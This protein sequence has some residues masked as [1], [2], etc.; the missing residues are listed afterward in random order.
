MIVVNGEVSLDSKRKVAW[1]E[2]EAELGEVAVTLGIMLFFL[3]SSELD[4][5]KRKPP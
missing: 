3:R 4:S 1:I 5:K 2:T